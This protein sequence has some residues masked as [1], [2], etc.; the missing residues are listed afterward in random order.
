M[1][2]ADLTRYLDRADATTAHEVDAYTRAFGRDI[3]TDH[4]EDAR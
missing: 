1:N 4:E 2:L 3:P